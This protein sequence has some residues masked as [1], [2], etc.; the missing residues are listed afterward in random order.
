MWQFST[1]A[2]QTIFDSGRTAARVE[3]VQAREQQALA[4]DQWA[5][6]NAFRETLDAL[7]AQRKAR[8]TLELEQLRVEALGRARCAWRNRATTTAWRAC[9]TCS[10]PNADRWTRD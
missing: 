4:Q 9:W 5:I 7:V 3:A 8:E 10:T 6:Q 2:A 1:G